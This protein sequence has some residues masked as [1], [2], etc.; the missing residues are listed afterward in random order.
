MFK[1][2]KQRVDEVGRVFGDFLISQGYRLR[3][4]EGKI[5]EIAVTQLTDEPSV[6]ELPVAGSW[7]V[8]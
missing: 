4:G 8:K 3:Y 2:I 1:E 5:A 6:V 7:Q